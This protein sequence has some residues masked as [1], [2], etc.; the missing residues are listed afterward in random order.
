MD[1]DGCRIVMAIVGYVD[2]VRYNAIGERKWAVAH[3]NGNNTILIQRV[4]AS[5]NGPDRRLKV[6][7]GKYDGSISRDITS[8]RFSLIKITN[9]RCCSV[10]RKND[11][12]HKPMRFSLINQ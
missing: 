2:E 12:S 6:N 9:Y 5:M 3:E 4:I 7:K 1:S 11:K 8:L 10:S